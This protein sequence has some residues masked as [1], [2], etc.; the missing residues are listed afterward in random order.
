MTSNICYG[1]MGALKSGNHTQKEFLDIMEQRYKRACP[2]YI[3]SLTCTPCKKVIK[4][5]NDEINK[6][7]HY[8]KLN[9]TYKLSK[10]K[11][12]AIRNLRTKCLKCKNKTRRKCKLSDY[13][14]FSGAEEGKCK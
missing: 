9:K 12:S 8:K 14:A 5:V 13:I 7:I 1:G 4:Q 11:D 2:L 10:K 6:Q 3:K